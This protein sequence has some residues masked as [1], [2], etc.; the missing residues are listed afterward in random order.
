MSTQGSKQYDNFQDFLDTVQYSETGVKRYEWIFGEGYLST[1]G[2][3]TTKE[4]VPHMHLTKGAKVLDVGCGLGGHD[5]YMAEEFGAVIDAIDLSK[6]MMSVALKHFSK[7]PNLAGNIKFR[8]CDVSA[9]NFEDN[10]YDVIYSRDALLHI[11]G[12]PEL[13][14]QFFK[15]LKPGGRLVFTDYC[16]GEIKSSEE[17]ENYVKQRAYTLYEVKQYEKLMDSCGFVNV[18]AED[19]RDKFEESLNKELKKLYVGR[20]EF[21]ELF[22][23]NDFVDLENGWLAKIKRMKDGHQ[24]WGMFRAQKPVD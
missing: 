14:R 10:Y 1:G 3:E 6:N 20:T 13:F 2:F 11:K 24:T 5:F 16:R 23:H 8:I 15:W 21:L 9:T 7:K 22:N 17:F 19:I 12:K 4:I 18:V